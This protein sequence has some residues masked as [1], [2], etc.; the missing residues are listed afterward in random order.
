M[1]CNGLNILEADGPRP[2][3]P[4][5]GSDIPGQAKASIPGTG[6]LRGGLGAE[7][8]RRLLWL[9]PRA[10]GLLSPPGRASSPPPLQ[11]GSMT[12]S[13]AAA[14]PSWK[15][16]VWRTRQWGLKGQLA[17]T[18]RRPLRR[19]GDTGL[20]HTCRAPG[21]GTAGGSAS[22]RVGGCDR[23][24]HLCG[25][26]GDGGPTSKTAPGCGP[27]VAPAFSVTPFWVFPGFLQCVRYF[28]N[29]RSLKLPSRLGAVFDVW[30]TVCPLSLASAMSRALSWG[31][32]TLAPEDPGQSSSSFLRNGRDRGPCLGFLASVPPRGS[33]QVLGTQNTRPEGLEGRREARPPPWAALALASRGVSRARCRQPWSWSLMDKGKHSVA[34]RWDVAGLRDGGKR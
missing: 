7:G 9:P 21:R 8:S 27:R 34:T 14:R 20:S 11:T 19:A 32:E 15:L 22:A 4:G 16:R 12:R 2:A 30:A 6:L 29:Q 10:R 28:S 24:T 26:T 25:K 17:T 3:P 23:H 18:S 1:G 13:G 33:R 5:P 31:A